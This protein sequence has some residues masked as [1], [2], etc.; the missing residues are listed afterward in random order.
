MAEL[1]AAGDF[2]VA[3]STYRHRV[4]QLSRE[5]API[6]FEPAVEPLIVRP[7]GIGIVTGSEHPAQALL[8]TE[9]MLTEVQEMLIDFDRTPASQAIEGGGVPTKFDVLEA[10]LE[11]LFND[12][13]KW[14]DLW[15]EI[16]SSSGGIIE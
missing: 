7:N 9:F 16:V 8:F 4:A 14:E 15:D 1:L 13:E 2:D 10:D 5:G 3:A 6:A 11:L 12:R